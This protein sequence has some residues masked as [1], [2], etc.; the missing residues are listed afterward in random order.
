[1]KIVRFAAA[2]DQWQTSDRELY[3]EAL[4]GIDEVA[5][6]IHLTSG[7]FSHGNAEIPGL[8]IRQVAVVDGDARMLSVA[9]ASVLAKVVRDRMMRRMDALYP[10]YGF[11]SHVGYITP[12]HSAVV[13]EIGPSEIHRRSFQALCYA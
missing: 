7:A 6:R 1:M 4:K 11:R 2:P 9:A 3:G 8:A 5:T 12:R 10:A 13:R